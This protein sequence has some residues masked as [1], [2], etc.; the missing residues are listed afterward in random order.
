MPAAAADETCDVENMLDEVV[1]LSVSPV[2]SAFNWDRGDLL[3]YGDGDAGTYPTGQLEVKF[4]DINT[5]FNITHYD[6]IAT[7]SDDPGVS[8]TLGIDE[9]VT[10]VNRPSDVGS[11]VTA[12]L[13]LQ[14]GTN[15]DIDVVAFFYSV[16][17]SP[18]Q[19]NQDSLGATTFLSPP[20]LGGGV[21][22]RHS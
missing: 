19:S 9:V 14:P 12:T 7:P 21:V 6:V 3:S 11:V 8:E 2:E 1:I 18:N 16:Q 4:N 15:Y 17:V 22:S 13:D 5:A 10:S 20:F